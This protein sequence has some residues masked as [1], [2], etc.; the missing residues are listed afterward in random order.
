MKKNLFWE[1]CKNYAESVVFRPNVFNYDDLNFPNKID[2]QR[3]KNLTKA[4]YNLYSNE[5]SLKN[6][7]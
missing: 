4:V 2:K 3:A 6:E 7:K 1:L 5:Q